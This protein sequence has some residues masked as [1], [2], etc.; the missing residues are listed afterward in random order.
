MAVASDAVRVA[1]EI[2]VKAAVGHPDQLGDCELLEL[3]FLSYEVSSGLQSG[4]T[5]ADV[6]LGLVRDWFI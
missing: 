5:F 1:E 3:G 2:F 4:L 6:R